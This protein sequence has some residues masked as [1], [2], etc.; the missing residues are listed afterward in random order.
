MIDGLSSRQGLLMPTLFRFALWCAV[1]IGVIYGILFALANF[2]E[3]RARDAI[4][5]IPSERLNP[6]ANS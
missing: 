5:E 3:P 1:I 6:P 4:I 2:V